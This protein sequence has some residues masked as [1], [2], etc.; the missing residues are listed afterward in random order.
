MRH[1]HPGLEYGQGTR[2]V[3][4]VWRVDLQS[5]RAEKLLDDNRYVHDF[6]ATPDG[7]R[8]ALITTPDD[9]V[10]S[11]EGQS[12]VDILDVEAGKLTSLPDQLWR[13]EALRPTAGW[14]RS[15]GQQTVGDWPTTLSLT[16]IPP[17]SS[18]PNLAANR[19]AGD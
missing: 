8:L 18:S 15:P 4:R 16:L 19:R 2:K 9:R 7:S 3:L 1:K 14:R 6:A 17:K 10:V 11:F 5:W 12:R 13:A